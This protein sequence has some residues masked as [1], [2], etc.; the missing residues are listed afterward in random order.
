[1]FFQREEDKA[2][3]GKEPDP[4]AAPGAP[5]VGAE[6]EAE[7]PPRRRRRR[8]LDEEDF[9]DFNDPF[10]DD[11]DLQEFGLGQ[12][13]KPKMNGYFMWRGPVETVVEELAVG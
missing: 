13:I 3:D 6:A 2:E 11:S 10:I 8:K 5:G 12:I 7:A 1:M 9:Y 4:D